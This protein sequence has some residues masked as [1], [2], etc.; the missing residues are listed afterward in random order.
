MVTTKGA[1]VIKILNRILDPLTPNRVAMINELNAGLGRRE[2]DAGE[3][4]I[5]VNRL[6]GL[7]RHEPDVQVRAAVF[8]LFEDLF[9]DRVCAD[10]ILDAAVATLRQLPVPCLMHA[11]P[12]IAYSKRADKDLI[13][14]P[15]MSSPDTTVRALMAEIG[16]IGSLQDLRKVACAG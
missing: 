4:K 16:R 3:R 9:Y 12:I 6:I 14:A 10:E 1:A 5:I 13:L 7:A 2:Y 8:N 15:Y 11:L